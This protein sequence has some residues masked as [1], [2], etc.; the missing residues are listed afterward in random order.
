MFQDRTDAGRRLSLSLEKYKSQ[1]PLVLAIPCG[2]VELGYQIALHLNCNM[3][4]IISR[5]LPFPN[6]PEAGFGAIAEDGSLFIHKRFASMFSDSELDQIIA[7]QQNEIDRRITIFRNGRPAPEIQ[8]KTV[9]L[10]DD[11][12]AMGSTMQAAIMMCKKKAASKIIVAS[13]VTSKDI[14]AQLKEIADEV[15]ILK[16][17]D[18]FRAVAQ[19]YLNWYDVPDEEVIKILSS[20]ETQRY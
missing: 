7:R 20:Y 2:G 12:I 19:V 15:Y 9:I 16:M 17:P 11:G 3:S 14:Y 10:V 4:I 8:D 5:K 6:D 18:D 13:A 1:N